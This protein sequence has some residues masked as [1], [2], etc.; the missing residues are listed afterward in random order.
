MPA[1]PKPT[2][3]T[4]EDIIEIVGD[5]D[6]AT[7]AAILATGASVAEVEEA[8]RRAGGETNSATEIHPLSP[9]AEAVYDI[10]MTTPAFTPQSN[11]R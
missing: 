10:L 2:P 3:P 4:H 6:D 11:E 5:L 9:S 8:A 1:D 7:V